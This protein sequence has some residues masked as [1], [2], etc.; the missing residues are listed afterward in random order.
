MISPRCVLWWAGLTVL[1]GPAIFANPVFVNNFSFE[2]LPAPVILHTTNCVGAGCEYTVASENAIPGW[3]SSSPADQG[4]FAPGVSS[5]NTNYYNSVPDGSFVAYA[6][7]GNLTQMVGTVLPNTTYTLSVS[8]GLR[9]DFP[10][11]GTAELFINGTA[12][13]ATGVTPTPGNWATFTATYNSSAHPGDV[14]MPI[15]IELVS[16]GV[17]AGFDDVVLN[18]NAVATPEPSPMALM[19]IGVIGLVVVARKKP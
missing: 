13:T 5:G 17:Q 1:L 3:T 8:L 16:N 7:A 14:G 15:T 6:N 18:A 19:G 2:T 12:Y 11:L 4:Q 10:T 9:K